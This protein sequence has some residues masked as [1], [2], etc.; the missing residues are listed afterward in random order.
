MLNDSHLFL[1]LLI[2]S[3][4]LT[5]NHLKSYAIM[6]SGSLRAPS[7]TPRRTGFLYPPC[8]GWPAESSFPPSEVPAEAPG[9]PPRPA[10]PDRSWA[11]PGSE[12]EDFP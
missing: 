9:R 2:T 7:H 4:L 12:Y 11:R 8:Y 1:Y 6:F 10:G 3:R 5:K